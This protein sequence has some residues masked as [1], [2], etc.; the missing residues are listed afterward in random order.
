MRPYLLAAMLCGALLAPAAAPAT[1]APATARIDAG[2]RALWVWSSPDSELLRF[3]GRHGIDTLY[4]HVPPGHASDR[5]F[6]RLARRAAD[7]GIALWAMAGHPRW[8]NETR[9]VV[10]WAREVVRSGLYEGLV[11]DIEPYVLDAWKTDER[12]ALLRRYLRRLRRAAQSSGGLPF[13]ATVPFWYDHDRYRHRGRSL[14]DQVLE[15]VDG[16]VVLVYRDRA[17]GSDGI[18]TLAAGE[19]SRAAD[20]G[21]QAVLGIQ[22]AADELDK[23]TFFEEGGVAME[24]E[25]DTV[26]TALR[27]AP[28][29]GG[30]AIHHY[31]SLR[32][33]RD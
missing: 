22:T 1:V 23:L 30:I 11:V 16:I 31:N 18:L 7:A 17:T 21:K 26:V 28:G 33:L 19:V 12:A 5:V 8:A 13:L 6:R 25:L 15:A 4:V 27:N 32:R 29:F 14:L 10:R 3:A 20:L 9:T 24:T 2:Q